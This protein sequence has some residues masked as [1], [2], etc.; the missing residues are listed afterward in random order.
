MTQQTSVRFENESYPARPL[1]QPEQDL[2]LNQ[3]YFNIVGESAVL[4][5]LFRDNEQRVLAAAAVAKEKL[6][7][8]AFTGMYAGNGE[9][10][11]RMIRSCD[12]LR[13]TGATET[14]NLDWEFTF[15]SGN[16]YWIGFGADNT[17]AINIDRRIGAIAVLGVALSSGASPVVE[18]IYP[19]LGSTTYP[20]QVVRHMWMADNINQ[21]RIARIRPW[22]LYQGQT[23]LVQVRT[24]AAGVNQLVALGVTFGRGDYLGLL[25]P[26]TV[27]V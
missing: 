25:A 18:D 3:L 11:M 26:T 20:I 14:P 15:S 10:G 12:I 5:R 13:T 27:Q 6:N 8:L 24:R 16:D 9:M 22:L 2:L 7:G 19:Q 17:T 23:T 21:V 1:S 4:Q